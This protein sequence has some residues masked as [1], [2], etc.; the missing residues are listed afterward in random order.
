[1]NEYKTWGEVASAVLQ[2]KFNKSDNSTA[3]AIILGL[4]S[5]KS[6]LAQK[7]LKAIRKLHQKKEPDETI[8][9]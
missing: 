6:E 7:A 8:R 4:R 9:N 5:D 3:E 2:G 1:M